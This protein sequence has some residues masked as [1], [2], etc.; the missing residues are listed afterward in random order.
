MKTTTPEDRIL[1]IRLSYT[2]LVKFHLLL[3]PCIQLI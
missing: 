1:R 2:W 3:I